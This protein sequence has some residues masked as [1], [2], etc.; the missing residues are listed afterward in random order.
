MIHGHVVGLQA[1]VSVAVDSPTQNTVQLEFVI[2]TGFEGALTMPTDMIAELGLPFIEEMT[3][4]PANGE[5]V[6]TDV[7]I[8]RIIWDE[9]E[10]EASVPALGSRPLLGTSLLAG[11]DLVAQF[12]DAGLIT[13]DAI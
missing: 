3:A 4:K 8:S 6:R 12:V 5:T 13:I 7:H 10:V 11:K 2:D 1:R 9:T